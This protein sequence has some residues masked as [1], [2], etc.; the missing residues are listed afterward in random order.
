MARKYGQ[1]DNNPQREYQRLVRNT[2][3]KLRRIE[4]EY[5]LD[6][7]DEIKIPKYE[8]LNSPE[9]FDEFAE[10]MSSFTD[11]GNLRYQFERN[12][13]GVVYSKQ[14]LNE[15]IAHTMIAQE[16]AREF[17]DKYKDN[18]Y[19]VSG[20]EAG[21]TVGERMTLFERENVAG[22]TVP[23]DFDID[24]FESRSRL[25]GRLELLGEKASGKFFDQSM[26]RMKENFMR[27]VRGSFNSEADDVLDMIDIIPPDDFFELFIMKAEF[28]FEDYASDGSIDGSEQ[29]LEMLRGYLQ[30]YFRGEI[31]MD[32]KGF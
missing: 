22:I 28:T 26:S 19:Y 3:A 30:S 4:D 32:M 25:K 8:E 5:G 1:R 23:N 6:L 31:D 16:K 21:Y 17:I 10:R 7:S 14:E 18:P 2:K 27:A 11:R 12:K 15:G 9:K 20:K 13:K 29:Q 24:A